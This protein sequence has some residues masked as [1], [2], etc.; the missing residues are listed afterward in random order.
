MISKK[1]FISKMPKEIQNQLY[2]LAYQRDYFF[3][4]RKKLLTITSKEI[5]LMDEQ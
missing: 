2:E 4:E 5:N 1:D 3:R